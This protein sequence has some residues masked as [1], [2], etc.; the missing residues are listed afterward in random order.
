MAGSITVRFLGMGRIQAKLAKTHEAVMGEVQDA[1]DKAAGVVTGQAKNLVPVDS[2]ALKA[3][4]HPIKAERKGNKITSGTSASKEYAAFVEFGTGVRG[5]G[6]Y[7]H[8]TE[9]N[10]AYSTEHPGQL[11]QPYM[12]PALARKSLDVKKLVREAFIRGILKK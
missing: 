8:P 2:G 1:L 5:S 7:P 9:P 4:I 10:L 6:S 12:Y 3:S 11:A